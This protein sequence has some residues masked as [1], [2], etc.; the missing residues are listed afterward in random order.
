MNVKVGPH[1]EVDLEE[2]FTKATIKKI[3]SYSIDISES[4]NTIRV[5]FYD[6]KGKEIRPKLKCRGKAKKVS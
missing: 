4:L 1:G 3:S 6:S 5:W 2:L